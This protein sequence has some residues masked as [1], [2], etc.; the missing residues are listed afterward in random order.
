MFYNAGSDLEIV[1]GIV[2]VIVL[3]VFSINNKD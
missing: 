2:L 1:I 3:A